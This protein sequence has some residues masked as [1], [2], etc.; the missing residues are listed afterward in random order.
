MKCATALLLILLLTPLARAQQNWLIETVDTNAAGYYNDIAL[1]SQ[2]RPNIAYT[3]YSLGTDLMLASRGPA[4]WATMLVDGNGDAGEYCSLAMDVGDLPH[5]SYRESSPVSRLRHVTWWQGGWASEI[6][7]PDSDGYWTSIALNLNGYPVISHFTEGPRRVKVSS[8]SG[9]VWS[10]S[11]VS[12]NLTIWNETALGLAGSGTP[13][14]AHGYYNN[15]WSQQTGANTWSS[16]PFFT[17]GQDM[18][19]QVTYGGTPHIVFSDLQYVYYTT[20]TPSGWNTENI[21]GARWPSVAVNARGVPFVSYGTG[22]G[23]LWVAH[24]AGPEWMLESVDFSAWCRQTSMA[25]DQ[26]GV[27]HVA[28][29]DNASGS[30]RYARSPRKRAP[31]DFDGDG[32]SDLAVYYPTGGKWY[33]MKSTAGYQHKLFGFAGTTPVTGDF[34]DDGVTDF[35]CYHAV[36][37]KWYLS[38]SQ[39]GYV[40]HTFGY[41]GTVPITADMDGDGQT[42]YGVYDHKTG[43]WYAMRSKAGYWKQSFGYPGTLPC[44]GDFDGDGTDDYGVYDPATGWWFIM[45]SSGTFW[46]L[47]FGYAGTVPVVGDFDGDSKCDGGVFHA[48]SGDMYLLM[49]TAGFSGASYLAANR[50]AVTGDF[51]GDGCLDTGT[52][53]NGKWYLNRSTEG[54][55]LDAFGSGGAIPIGAH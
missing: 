47:W 20:R 27:L 51:D 8:K 54:A 5:I 41:G 30:L 43:M 39:L 50:V 4:G 15:R 32:E 21:A 28:Y 44:T 35:G 6:A 38:R 31:N 49:S 55:G 18:D 13:Q 19:M 34:D 2:G 26:Y 37:G 40:E 53:Q 3:S 25:M 9:A 10:H 12:S 7:D 1:D 11:V 22:N 33:F 24:K 46:P 17:G 14:V 16:E 29:E 48:A 42:D 45:N 23:G 52:F 36:G